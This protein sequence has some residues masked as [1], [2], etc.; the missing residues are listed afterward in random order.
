MILDSIK[1]TNINN[2]NLSADGGEAPYLLQLKKIQRT[3]FSNT[4]IVPYKIFTNNKGLFKV[5]IM[6][7]KGKKLYDKRQ[8][9]KDRDMKRDLQRSL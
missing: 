9:I 3:F 6:I 5:E 8:T 1:N 4:T 2:P 7:A